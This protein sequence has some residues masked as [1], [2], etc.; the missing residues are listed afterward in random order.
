MNTQPYYL[1]L[2]HDE[3]LLVAP[4]GYDLDV[5][6]YIEFLEEGKSNFKE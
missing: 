5:P 4:R 1:I 3:E 2:N 6:G